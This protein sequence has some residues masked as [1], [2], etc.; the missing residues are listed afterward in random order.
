VTAEKAVICDGDVY[1]VDSDVALACKDDSLVTAEKAVICDGD[2]YTVDSDV[3]L[4][5]KDDDPSETVETTVVC[6]GDV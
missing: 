4:A 5:Y 3:A 2:V 1:T 6:P